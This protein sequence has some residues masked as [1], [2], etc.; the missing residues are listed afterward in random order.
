MAQHPA[1]VYKRMHA[2]EQAKTDHAARTETVQL[3]AASGPSTQ[4]SGKQWRPSEQGR[5]RECETLP[6]SA[7]RGHDKTILL[8]LHLFLERG[9]LRLLQAA[10]Q[11]LRA[12]S[13]LQSSPPASV[14]RA[15]SLPQC[16][17]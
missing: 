2:R 12:P 3:Y 5:A 13:E 6:S 14:R 8:R 11:M 7:A 10:S 1:R 16:S 4:R 9:L 15:P 17:R